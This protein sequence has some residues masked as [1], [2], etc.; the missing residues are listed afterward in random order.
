MTKAGYVVTLV[1]TGAVR[2]EL[3][4]VAVCEDKAKAIK[5][6][7]KMHR[8]VLRDVKGYDIIDDDY[9]PD[10]YFEIQIDD[11]YGSTY[12]GEITKVK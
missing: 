10:D 6:L 9:E 7:E 11:D 3:D 2:L 8:E 1:S 5:T 4:E 12:H